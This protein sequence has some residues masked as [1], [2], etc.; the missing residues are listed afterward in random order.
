MN[1][2][3]WPHHHIQTP[4][5]LH[6]L[7]YQSLDIS[8]LAH[9]GPDGD[10]LGGV[11]E[12][13]LEEGKGFVSGLE[14]N[15]RKD[16]VCALEREQERRLESDTTTKFVVLARCESEMTRIVRTTQRP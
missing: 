5:F 2:V 10:R 14:I 3:I 4:K 16:N 6:C 11:G 1:Q 9:I 15:V 12:L 7:V 13:L 8:L